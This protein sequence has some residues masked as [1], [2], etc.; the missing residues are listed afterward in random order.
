MDW[1]NAKEIREMENRWMANRAP[2]ESVFRP[3]YLGLCALCAQPIWKVNGFEELAD[4]A[5]HGCEGPF[6]EL[7]EKN[8]G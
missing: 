6:T 4:R 7:E 2:Q 5:L 8:D 1:P 3:L